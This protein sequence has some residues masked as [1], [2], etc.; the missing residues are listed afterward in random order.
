MFSLISPKR[1]TL[2]S[3]DEI[4]HGLQEK[5]ELS[6]DTKISKSFQKSF[7]ILLGFTPMLFSQKVF[8]SPAWHNRGG[9]GRGGRVPET[10]DQEI[11]VD[12]PGKERQG[13][14]KRENGAEKKENWK[15]EGDFFFFL[16]FAF[17]NH[18]PLMSSAPPPH[19]WKFLNLPLQGYLK[20]H[21]TN[22]RLIGTHLNVFFIQNLI[23]V[24]KLNFKFE[25][26]FSLKKVWHI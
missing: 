19:H 5:Y 9:G 25:Y 20:N 2:F 21:S 17:Q 7:K 22:P 14:W 6:Y 12:L 10:S 3:C 24:I 8:V 23:M 11:S 18:I 26:E 1:I 13:K 4:C 15:R 16:L